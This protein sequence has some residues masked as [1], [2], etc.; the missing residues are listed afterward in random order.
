MI[1]ELVEAEVKPGAEAEFE[2]AYAQAIAL[3]LKAKG[4][5]SVRM[6][7]GIERPSVFRILV[8]WD[9][10][11]DHTQGFRGSPAH[12]QLISLTREHYAQPALVQHYAV[13]TDTNA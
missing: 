8:Q 10:I 5:R 7:R 6:M 9:S 1:Y 2:T 11:E 3:L 12:Q 4:C 13:V